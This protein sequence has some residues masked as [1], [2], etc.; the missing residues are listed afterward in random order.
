MKHS[1]WFRYCIGELLVVA[2]ACMALILLAVV[3]K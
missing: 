1:I 3:W 2:V